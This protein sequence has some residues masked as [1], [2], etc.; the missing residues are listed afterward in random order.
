[1][2]AASSGGNSS[3]LNVSFKC[4]ASLAPA[5]AGAVARWYFVVKPS[6]AY[7]LVLLSSSCTSSTTGARA[8]AA[9]PYRLRAPA[10]AEAEPKEFAGVFKGLLRARDACLRGRRLDDMEAGTKLDVA[11]NGDQAE[12]AG[13]LGRA[14][15][16][17]RGIS[18]LRAQRALAVE[19]ALVGH[20]SQSILLQMSTAYPG[21]TASHKESV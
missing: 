11:V 7:G 16:A 13:K 19:L 4:V 15:T 18:L 12:R 21:S 6:S 9:A 10:N 20:G 14:K 3:G 17:A 2:R 8:K 1:M 5:S